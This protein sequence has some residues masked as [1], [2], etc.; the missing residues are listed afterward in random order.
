MRY[1]PIFFWCASIWAQFAG[2]AVVRGEL[3]I[4]GDEAGHDYQVELANCAGGSATARGRMSAGNQFEFPDVEQ[5]CKTL[6]VLSGP[7]RNVVQEVEIFAKESSGP[8]VIHVANPEKERVNGET[9]SVGRL[10]HPA[11]QKVVRAIADANR[12]WKAGQVVEAREKLRPLVAKY[13]EIWELQLNLGVIEMKLQNVA[14]AAEHFSKA[15][16]LEPRS[17]VAAVG[18]GFALLQLHRLEEAEGAAKDAIALEPGNQ[19]ARLLLA[20]IQAARTQGLN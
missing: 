11:P 2:H 15:R 13:P 4:E 19:A 14:A 12:L 17:P 20:R 6:R 8:L 16:E 7:Q 10:R 1:F 5:G 3:Q 18:S 9:V